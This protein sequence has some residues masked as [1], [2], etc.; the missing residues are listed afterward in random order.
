MKVCFLTLGCKVNQTENLALAEQAAREGF[1]IVKE[2]ENP[3]ALII[4]TCTVTAIGSK[5][6][7]QLI[8]RV[9]KNHPRSLVV[10]MGCYAQ[11]HPG[12]V[13][14]IE[15]IDLVL[16]TQDRRLVVKFL[17][18]MQG[19][20][21]DKPIWGVKDFTRQGVAYE[22]L[23]LISGSRRV[24]AMLKIQDGCSQ[25]CTY[26]I[27]PYARG[28][29]RSRKPE[30]IIAETKQL[31][32]AGYKE[33]VLTGIHI[34][35]YGQD[36]EPKTSLAE[37]ISQLADL[38]G[39]TR[40]RLG[41]IEPMEFSEKLLELVTSK[42]VICPHFHIPL[43]SGA[44]KI[45]AL[46]G[47]PYS[48]ADYAMLLQRIR[49]KLPE[50]A[51]T[52]DIMAGFPGEEDGDH[53][54]TLKFITECDFAS[55]HAFPYSRRPGTPAAEMPAQIA[56]KIKKARVRDLT[57]IGAESRKKYARKFVGSPVEVLVE[58]VWENGSAEGHT[59]NYLHLKIPPSSN[60]EK[61]SVGQLVTCEFKEEYLL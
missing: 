40:L 23:P 7:R 51:I 17:K 24:R 50:A 56:G 37:L 35:A 46:M 54:R 8:R 53:Q 38:D 43:Q 12:E 41:S 59:R 22:E 61:W 5:K 28:P 14:K 30:Q 34:G 18:E 44:D 10:V 3:D 49:K 4:N 42:Q 60:G 19:R 27:V 48:T 15:G 47:R 21:R 29:S 20:K 32:E 52:T 2:T 26:C 39:M 9:V 16:G 58:R 45:L 36:L 55:L 57:K 1:E 13:A 11:I 6:S 25:Y 33:I 31:L